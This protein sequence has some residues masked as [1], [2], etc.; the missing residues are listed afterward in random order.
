MNITHE[1]DGY[2]DY[3]FPTQRQRRQDLLNA[4]R[5]YGASF[6]PHKRNNGEVANAFSTLYEAIEVLKKYED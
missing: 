6:R 2:L 1:Q 4:I 3:E 5:D